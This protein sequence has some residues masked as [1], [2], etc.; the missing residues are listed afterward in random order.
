MKIATGKD[1]NSLSDNPAGVIK[2]KKYDDLIS[3]NTQYSGNIQNA[4]SEMQSANDNLTTVSDDFKL[5]GS[6]QLILL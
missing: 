4:L 1:I 2:V 6:R 3:R 5:S